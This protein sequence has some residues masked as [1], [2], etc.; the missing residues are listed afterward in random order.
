MPIC[1][2]LFDTEIKRKLKKPPALSI[3][4]EN[5]KNALNGE[6]L[7]P[8]LQDEEAEDVGGDAEDDV[9][10]DVIAELFTFGESELVGE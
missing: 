8:L 2:Q 1:G 7:F 9:Q 3:L 5:S 4:M 10:M 6:K